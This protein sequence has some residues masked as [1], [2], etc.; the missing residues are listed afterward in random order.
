MSKENKNVFYLLTIM[1]QP[2]HFLYVA[3]QCFGYLAARSELLANI[4]FC[5]ESC[6][7]DKAWSSLLVLFSVFGSNC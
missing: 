2:D 6:K 1:V 3:L 4:L 5:R 7:L